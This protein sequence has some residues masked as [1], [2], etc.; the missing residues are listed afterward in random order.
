MKRYD[1]FLKKDIH[2]ILTKYNEITISWPAHEISLLVP[3]IYCKTLIYGGHF[4]L[5]LFGVKTKI[6]KL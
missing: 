5:A 2:S 1:F 4:Y 3:Y 6:I